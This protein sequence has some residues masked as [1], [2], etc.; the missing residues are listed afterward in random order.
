MLLSSPHSSCGLQAHVCLG[1]NTPDRRQFPSQGSSLF[2]DPVFT[3]FDSPLHKQPH[4][5]QFLPSDTT[6]LKAAP[7]KKFTSHSIS[8]SSLPLSP[9]P[10]TP[11][12][13]HLFPAEQSL[14]SE[15][16]QLKWPPPPV[17]SSVSAEVRDCSWHSLFSSA[18][19]LQTRVKAHPH[20]TL[21]QLSLLMVWGFW[22]TE[23]SCYLARE[24]FSRSS[25]LAE[26]TGC[27]TT[28]NL[29]PISLQTVHF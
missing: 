13:P 11:Y 23:V 6:F 4:S 29:L 18:T 8:W 5:H 26:V 27:F 19:H 15:I 16:W 24:C 21:N 20:S 2:T 25:H 17:P 22:D 9:P 28:Q 1:E 10:T 12:V 3:L 14:V 7:N